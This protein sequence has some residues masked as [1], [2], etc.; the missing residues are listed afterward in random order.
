MPHTPPKQKEMPSWAEYIKGSL[1]SPPEPI[2]V[3]LESFSEPITM[4]CFNALQLLQEHL[5]RSNLY[6]N[7]NKLNIHPEH[8]WDQSFLPPSSHIRKGTDG[9][10][11]KQVISKYIKREAL[12][13][14]FDLDS[15]EK[16]LY[17]PFIISLEQYQ[18][19]TGTKMRGLVWNQLF[20][21]LGF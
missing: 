15:V 9:S 16:D 11:Y 3:Q 17:R 2:Q 18:D 21:P 12:H 14:H 5:L 1:K 6:R 8:Q 19:S 7:V 13:P 10:W 4:Y 20:S